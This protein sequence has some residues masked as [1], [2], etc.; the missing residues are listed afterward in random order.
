MGV[1]D[2]ETRCI[3]TNTYNKVDRTDY[4]GFITIYWKAYTGNLSNGG[5]WGSVNGVNNQWMTY[6]KN[7]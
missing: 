5:G 7:T 4:D 2:A 1:V 6:F 3:I